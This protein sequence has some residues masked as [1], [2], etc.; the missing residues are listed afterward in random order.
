[1]NFDNNLVHTKNDC[2]I[3]LEQQLNSLVLVFHFETGERDLNLELHVDQR[4]IFRLLLNITKKKKS[5]LRSVYLEKVHGKIEIIQK[6]QYFVRK[7]IVSVLNSINH[8]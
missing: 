6:W 7:K 5:F 4:I 1:M 2:S 8:S 3:L